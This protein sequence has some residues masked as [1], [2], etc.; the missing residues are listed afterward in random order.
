MIDPEYPKKANTESVFWNTSAHELFVT[1]LLLWDT[2]YLPEAVSEEKMEELGV[3]SPI[4]LQCSLARTIGLNAGLSIELFLKAC[5]VELRGEL[6]NN[7]F[8]HDLVKIADSAGVIF[9]TQETEKLS[10]LTEY[11]FWAGKYPTGKFDSSLKD[12]VDK[13]NASGVKNAED[14]N[15]CPLQKSEYLKLWEKI[16]RHYFCIGGFGEFSEEEEKYIKPFKEGKVWKVVK[17]IS[18]LE[19][20]S[21]SD[22]K[23]VL[24][25]AE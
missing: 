2:Y 24:T 19:T 10:I 12:L 21:L 8:H 15:T 7:A 11:I 14:Y 4:E 25:V 22:H 3:N 5:L 18:D 6:P 17:E 16:K 9:N 13:M 1:S 20:F 23:T